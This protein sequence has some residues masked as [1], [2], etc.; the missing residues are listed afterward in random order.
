MPTATKKSA[1]KKSATKKSATTGFSERI[2]KYIT[3]SGSSDKA[4]ALIP[5]YRDAAVAMH[6]AWTESDHEAMESGTYDELGGRRI[7]A[8]AVNG[9]LLDQN[10]SIRLLITFT[11]DPDKAPDVVVEEAMNPAQFSRCLNDAYVPGANKAITKA[12]AKQR[13]THKAIGKAF[14]C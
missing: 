6:D 10:Q 1:T 11:K 12:N 3:V 14:A 9:R 13:R 5:F 4:K 8:H 7:G 2:N